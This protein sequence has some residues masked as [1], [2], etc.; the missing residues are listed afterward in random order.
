MKDPGALLFTV[1]GIGI[2]LS[3]HFVS[4][5]WADANATL[6]DLLRLDDEG[7]DYAHGAWCLDCG[8]RGSHDCY[9]TTPHQ[10]RGAARVDPGL[11]GR[12]QHA[13]D[14]VGP[15]RNPVVSHPADC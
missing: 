14:T 9:P 15:Q 2:G 1:L 13:S 5:W 11:A 3:W 10:S 8:E 6:D 12:G 4:R 7:D